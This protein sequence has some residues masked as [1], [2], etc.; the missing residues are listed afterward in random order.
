MV[1]VFGMGNKHSGEVS[2]KCSWQCL[3]CLP[4][5]QLRW[6]IAPNL[7]RVTS[8]R[9][10]FASFRS[11]AGRCPLLFR[12][13]QSW[14]RCKPSLLCRGWSG[15]QQLVLFSFGFLIFVCGW[16]VGFW[17]YL[18]SIGLKKS[19][20]RVSGEKRGLFSPTEGLFALIRGL[21]RGAY[22]LF[23]FQSHRDSFQQG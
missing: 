22:G 15:W 7:L 10:C 2:F 23:L 5:P 9:D 3:Y 16:K 11:A 13:S 14:I 12:V 6:V 1:R 20:H 8:A 17:D 4:A 19:C 18:S 21:S